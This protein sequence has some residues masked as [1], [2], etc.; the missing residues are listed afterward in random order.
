M[1]RCCEKQEK[2][3][4]REEEGKG[5]GQSMLLMEV[6]AAGNAR[7]RV[8]G[9]QSG[10][11]AVVIAV[12]LCA[13]HVLVASRSVQAQSQPCDPRFVTSS[14]LVPLSVTERTYLGDGVEGEEVD[15]EDN[16]KERKDIDLFDY[17]FRD[18][19]IPYP[20]YPI[21]LDP[22]RRPLR[23]MGSTPVKSG[24]MRVREHTESAR[25]YPE[26]K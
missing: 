14:A 7:G 18:T 20:I 9:K 2:T 10:A 3:K 23:L 21:R 12:L 19:F 11:S 17:S 4:G 16:R 8:R 22:L 13:A 25:S 5:R 24:T 6:R 1:M 15:G 26:S